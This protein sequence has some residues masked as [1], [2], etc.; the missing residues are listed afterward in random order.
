MELSVDPQ[1]AQV[2]PPMMS[3]RATYTPKTSSGAGSI[4]AGVAL[5]ALAGA[6][7]AYLFL[8]SRPATVTTARASP[9]PGGVERSCEA[10]RK[11]LQNGADV[12][13][14]DTYGWAVEIWL[15]RMDAP[16]LEP[17]DPS[18]AK[19]RAPD[20]ALDPSFGLAL[21]K[22]DYGEVA[23][24][25][26][27][28]P[29][30]YKGKEPGVVVRLSGGYAA[31]FFAGGT[32][33]SFLKLAD[34][35]YESS[36]A[37]I[38]AL[39]ARCAHLPYHDVGAWFRAK[40]PQSAADVIGYQMSGFAEAPWVARTV[41]SPVGDGGSSFESYRRRRAQ[42]DPK[43]MDEQVRLLEGSEDQASGGGVTILFP[44]NDPLRASSMARWITKQAALD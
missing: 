9:P 29:P 32:R 5:L 1:R 27:P 36:G 35:A 39:Y 21:P 23:F 12:G 44:A 34:T 41:F 10:S 28:S 33:P 42:V 2:R 43:A 8:R 31:A 4:I 15:A 24:E 7:G 20:G 37:T 26:A 6:A 13:P 11:R 40:D 30:P 22:E 3:H 17:A 16:E 38:G 19:L 18:L 14:L 25:T